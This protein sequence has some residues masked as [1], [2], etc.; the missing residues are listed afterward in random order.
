MASQSI[1]HNDVLFTGTVTFVGMVLPASVIGNTQIATA[2]GIAASKLEHQDHSVYQ[3]ANGTANVAKRVG[4]KIVY[5]TT[6]VVLALKARNTTTAT[7]SDKTRIDLLKNGSTML[8]AL[9]DLDATAA[10]AVQTASL[11][12][13]ALV[14]GD[15]LELNVT[16]SGTAVGQGLTVDLVTREDAA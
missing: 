11:A 7:G 1:I 8:S 10:V 5:G 6:G 15:V 16:L 3:Q 2:A 12:S 4:V 9:L 13:T 14:A